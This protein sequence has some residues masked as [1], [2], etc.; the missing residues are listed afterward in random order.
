VA[1]GWGTRTGPRLIWASSV[2]PCES[3]L[4]SGIGM[5][6]STAAGEVGGGFSNV[7]LQLLNGGRSQQRNLEPDP[8]RWRPFRPPSSGAPFDEALAQPSGG[9]ADPGR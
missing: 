5:S 9:G 8:G 2:A 1:P 3:G 7:N 4:S 6:S